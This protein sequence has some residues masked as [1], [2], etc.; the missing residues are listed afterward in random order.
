MFYK[1]IDKKTGEELKH[2]TIDGF[3]YVLVDEEIPKGAYQYYHGQKTHAISKAEKPLINDGRRKLIIATN[4]PSLKDI[5]QLELEEDVEKLA[6]ENYKSTIRQHK[7][8]DF[9]TEVVIAGAE[10]LGFKEGYAKAKEKYQFTK[11]DM[12]EFTDWYN[13]VDWVR[14]LRDYNITTADHNTI[15]E[16]WQKQRVKIIEL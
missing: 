4:N 9:D 11:E 6:Y 8:K 13:N 7:E 1:F 12:I 10:M 15:I 3:I 14:M 16:L 5:P 2:V